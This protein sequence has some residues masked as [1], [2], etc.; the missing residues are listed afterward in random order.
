MNHRKQLVLITGASSGIG[1]ACVRQA[2]A[3]EYLVLGTGRSEDRLRRLAE[4]CGSAHLRTL[5][6]DLTTADGQAALLETASEA[7]DRGQ[8][9]AVVHAAGV[10][11]TGSGADLSP[12]DIEACLQ[13]NLQVP[14]QVSAALLPL[15]QASD[16]PNSEQQEAMAAVTTTSSPNA[17]RPVTSPTI[18]A[19]SSIAATNAFPGCSLYAAS[20]AGLEAW[21]RGL[22][23]DLRDR[24]I[25]VGIVRPGA[26][27]TP[28]WGDDCPFDRSKMIHPDTVAQAIM[29]MIEAP[30][31]TS[32]DCLD[33]YPSCGPL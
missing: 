8:V 21:A 3:A 28:I 30:A 17:P 6:V 29:Q 13:I 23:E 32:I 10:F 18:V 12:V 1:A 25:R 27:D 16:A 2:L 5:A 26:T 22:R 4:S 24:G 7:V 14:M 20:K 11:S 31:N 9:A 33:V 19:L 15:M